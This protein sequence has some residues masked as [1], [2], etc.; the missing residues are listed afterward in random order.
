MRHVRDLRTAF[1]LALCAAPPLPGCREPPAARGADSPSQDALPLV[2]FADYRIGFY[3][4]DLQH[5]RQLSTTFLALPVTH[6]ELRFELDAGGLL[7]GF[8]STERMEILD[9]LTAEGV[10]L[11]RASRTMLACFS[12]QLTA[13]SS[14]SGHRPTKACPTP[15]EPVGTSRRPG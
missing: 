8:D 7:P 1:I 13:T 4:V 3:N 10:K 2:D 14:S 12:T 6:C 11:R 15:G 9:V 5:H